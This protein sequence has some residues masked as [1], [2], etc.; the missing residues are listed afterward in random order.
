MDLVYYYVG[1]FMVWFSI[2][3]LCI[4]LGYYL[5]ESVHAYG[6]WKA[7]ADDFFGLNFK[8]EHK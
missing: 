1:E 6:G 5:S 8:E 3:A 7:W 4:G 2:M